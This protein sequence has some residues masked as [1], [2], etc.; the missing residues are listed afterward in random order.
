MCTC[1]YLGVELSCNA[2]TEPTEKPLFFLK[3]KH[4]SIVSHPSQF[5]IYKSEEGGS[6]VCVRHL[7]WY[8]PASSLFRLGT[9]PSI[10]QPHFLSKTTL[11][12]SGTA[13]CRK[14]AYC[15]M[16]N[17][18]RLRAVREKM[19]SP[20]KA[21][22]FLV[23]PRV[24]MGKRSLFVCASVREWDEKAGF[25]LENFASVSH[26]MFFFVPA[27]H[28]CLLQLTS[29]SPNFDRFSKHD[30]GGAGVVDCDG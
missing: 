14:L 13:L 29:P 28:G 5:E 25:E 2:P 4:A 21:E 22:M 12:M 17:C 15:S 19:F 11:R 9:S 27:V 3:P 20:P 8:R 7:V 26:S 30:G 23:L 10:F 1:L 24:G 16:P 6:Y 18:P